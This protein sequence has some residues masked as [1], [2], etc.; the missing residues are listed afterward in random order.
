MR[1]RK[2]GL[3][4]AKSYFALHDRSFHTTCL[5]GAFA[6][7]CV[8]SCGLFLA[9]EAPDGQID[10]LLVLPTLFEVNKMVLEGKEQFSTISGYQMPLPATSEL[11]R[12][13]STVRNRAV[14]L[15]VAKYRSI[16]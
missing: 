16:R 11:A 13:K 2:F 1:K 14:A 15:R 4:T 9:C 5:F 12:K 7:T 8:L 6:C 10:E 3:F